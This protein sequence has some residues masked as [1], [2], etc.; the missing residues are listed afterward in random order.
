M[1]FTRDRLNRLGLYFKGGG[2]GG[3]IK[4]TNDQRALADIAA[5]RWQRYQ[6]NF[7]PVENKYIGDATTANSPSRMQHATEQSQGAVRSEFG[8]AIASD[9]G[10]VT[11]AG[12]NP[13]SGTFNAHVD[14]GNRRMAI[15]ESDNVNKTQQAVDDRQIAGMKNVV[16]MG[17]GQATEALSGM[18]DV[19]T[20]SAQDAAT[21]AVNTHNADS[22]NKYLAAQVAGA[23]TR[24]AISGW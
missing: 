1:R 24:T 15:A 8:Q 19:A 16:A 12:I 11:A 17:N 21:K 13:N 2:G 14:D 20:A 6:Q 10:Q 9:L 3:D 18:G 4:E 23:G 22:E 7:V 5:Q